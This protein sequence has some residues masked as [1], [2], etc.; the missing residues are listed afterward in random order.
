MYRAGYYKDAAL[1][2]EFLSCHFPDFYWYSYNENIAK[3]MDGSGKGK[4]YHF[5][6]AS[7]F[8]KRLRIA[9]SVSQLKNDALINT[10]FDERDLKSPEIFLAK[11][12]TFVGKSD[13]EWIVRL[14]NYLRCYDL[15]PLII[16]AL[17]GDRAEYFLNLRARKLPK[18][19][20]PLVT[21]CMSCYNAERY[22]EHAVRSILAQTYQNIE[23]IL[24]ND[25]SSD[26]TLQILERL[27]QEDERITLIDN[28]VNQGAYRSRNQAFSKAKG[29]YFTV[30]DADDFALPQRIEMQ[31]KH[32]EV[33]P[34]HVGVF[35]DWIRMH[36]DGRVYFK[37]GWGGCYQH[38][39]AA[40]MMIRTNIARERVGFWDSV[41]FSADA[42]YRYRLYEVFGKN[43]LP[44]VK[45]PTVIS[46]FHNQ[47][48]TNDPKTGINTAVE[49]L[50]PTR[51][52]YRKSW[53]TWHKST[54]KD[55]LYL[56][57]PQKR[58]V[59]HAPAEML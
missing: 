46:L 47:S 8:Q 1:I 40:T 56:P 6:D 22:V 11:A 33:N 19:N 23:V 53:T 38:K 28:P 10:C 25:K 14:N 12:N 36:L 2:Y 48:L 26:N 44:R 52:E 5:L 32:L 18:I 9:D 31:V 30:L 59:F 54:K 49:G 51:V 27:Q 16:N 13:E 45:V 43:N 15:S 17:S 42:E 3:S 29:K 58:R 7:D 21:V 20:G 34:E 41:R 55:S 39:A 37:S 4:C 57:F 24:L 35:T 50:S